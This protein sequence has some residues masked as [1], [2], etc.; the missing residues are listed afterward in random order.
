MNLVIN[1]SLKRRNVRL[2]NLNGIDSS[3][4]FRIVRRTPPKLEK[5][6]SDEPV[7]PETRPDVQNASRIQ[8]PNEPCEEADL[9]E[10]TA[11]QRSYLH[12]GSASRRLGPGASLATGGRLIKVCGARTSRAANDL[13]L[14]LS[15]RRSSRLVERT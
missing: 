5:F 15:R 6:T 10:L 7:F 1:R 14:G 9:S 8:L 2:E 4:P 3:G 13:D 11:R 12:L